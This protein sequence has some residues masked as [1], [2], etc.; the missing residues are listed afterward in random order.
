MD[1]GWN[2]RSSSTGGLKKEGDVILTV[3]VFV[4]RVIRCAIPSSISKE[5]VVVGESELE[6][7]GSF[8][9]SKE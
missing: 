2:N 4:T 3:R 5:V 6:L 7:S 1:Q 9:V 8:F